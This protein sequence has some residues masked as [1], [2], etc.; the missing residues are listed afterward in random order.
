V[1]E[2]RDGVPLHDALVGECDPPAPFQLA[3][4]CR[5]S[6]RVLALTA[7]CKEEYTA[8][9]RLLQAMAREWSDKRRASMLNKQL[10][11]LGNK[12][13]DKKAISCA[14]VNCVFA[15]KKSV[16]LVRLMLLAINL[17]GL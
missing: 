17:C 2:G 3:V 9:M 15:I 14:C 5:R 1:Q 13:Y 12:N 6:G 4:R 7:T 8:W 16:Y 10:M 11:A